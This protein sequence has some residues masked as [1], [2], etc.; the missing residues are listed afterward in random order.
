MPQLTPSDI[1]GDIVGSGTVPGGL[2]ANL[3]VF[4]ADGLPTPDLFE[5]GG[6]PGSAEQVLMFEI[7]GQLPYVK[8]WAYPNSVVAAS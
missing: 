6:E 5:I 4:N 8:D 1:L 7:M 2:F 3:P